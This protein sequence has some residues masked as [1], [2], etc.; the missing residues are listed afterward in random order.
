MTRVQAL[1]LRKTKMPR[2]GSLTGVKVAFRGIRRSEA[3]AGSGYGRSSIGT[4]WCLRWRRQDASPSSPRRVPCPEGTRNGKLTSGSPRACCRRKSCRA[5][6]VEGACRMGHPGTGIGLLTLRRDP[7]AAFSAI[8]GSS[9]SWASMAAL[10][11]L[12]GQEGGARTR[13]LDRD[14]T[15]PQTQ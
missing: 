14:E 4:I 7:R 12:P 2:S 10:W 8:T 5:Y 9:W 13:R 3:G 6:S 1:C 15:A 11:G